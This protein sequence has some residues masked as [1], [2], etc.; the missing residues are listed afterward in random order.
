MFHWDSE[1]PLLDTLVQ[2]DQISHTPQYRRMIAAN[3]EPL[4]V[5]L[6]Q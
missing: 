3:P 5:Q 1:K 2:T 4:L 6:P